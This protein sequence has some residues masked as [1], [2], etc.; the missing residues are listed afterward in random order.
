MDIIENGCSVTLC[1]KINIYCPTSRDTNCYIDIKLELTWLKIVWDT[2]VTTS[3][4][5]AF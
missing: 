3:S 5:L 4:G 2:F 1:S